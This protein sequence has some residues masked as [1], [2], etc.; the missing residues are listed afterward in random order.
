MIQVSVS[1]CKIKD[2]DL[3]RYPDLWGFVCEGCGLTELD[4]SKNPKLYQLCC[5]GNELTDLN[6]SNNPKLEVLECSNNQLTQLDLSNNPLVKRLECDGNKLTKLD[7]SCCPK[8]VERVNGAIA[9][10]KDGSIEWN[11]PKD[12]TRYVYDRFVMRT[13]KDVEVI[14]EAGSE[15]GTAGRMIHFIVFV[16]R[17]ERAAA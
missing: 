1:G 7:I 8:L 2:L 6:L 4:V 17:E 14:T 5:N 12:S 15:K 16:G 13:D 10:E 3:R 9:E 11:L